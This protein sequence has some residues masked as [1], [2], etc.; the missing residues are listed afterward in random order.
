MSFIIRLAS[1]LCGP[2]RQPDADRADEDSGAYY[3]V[4]KVRRQ[5]SQSYAGQ[6]YKPPRM[7]RDSG[8][9]ASG[10]SS[11]LSSED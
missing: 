1:C 3:S 8:P 9:E 2:S 5:Y 4:D 11:P 7:K 6:I 10:T